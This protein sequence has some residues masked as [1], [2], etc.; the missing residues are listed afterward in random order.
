[1]RLCL[2]TNVFIA[3]KNREAD[4]QHCERILDAIDDKEIEGVIS[5]IVIT[6]TLVGF[7]YNKEEKEAEH[8][9]MQVLRSYRVLPVDVEVSV[10]A[11]RI[12]AL[13]GIKLPDAIIIATV[14]ITSADYLITKDDTL[15]KKIGIK[16]LTPKEFASKYLK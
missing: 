7:Y 14:I 15:K 16:S 4:S 8:F 13:Q 3:V 10:K 9:L 12:R 11:A 1:M 2:D 5:T 6:E